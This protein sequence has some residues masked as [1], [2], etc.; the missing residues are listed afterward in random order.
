MHTWPSLQH[1]S[2]TVALDG[3]NETL[4]SIALMRIFCKH[5]VSLVI[6]TDTTRNSG[7][8]TI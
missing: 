8:N 2:I 7:K 1:R 6:P 3:D 4:H 5:T